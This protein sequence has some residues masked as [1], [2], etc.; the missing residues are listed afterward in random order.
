MNGEESWFLRKPQPIACEPSAEV[1]SHLS[2]KFSSSTA[3]WKTVLFSPVGIYIIRVN[4]NLEFLG[5]G[6]KL[7]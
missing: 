4:Y 6:A 7:Q 1:M 2:A 5:H 3:S